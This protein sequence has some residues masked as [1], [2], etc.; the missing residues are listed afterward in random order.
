MLL[1]VGVVETGGTVRHQARL[2][3]LYRPRSIGARLPLNE[4]RYFMPRDALGA[5]ASEL[6]PG[7]GEVVM[8][9][10]GHFH[11]LTAARIHSAPGNL[12]LVVFDAHPDWS[13]APAGYVHCGSWVLEALAMPPVRAV[14]LVG[15]GELEARGLLQPPVVRGVEPAAREG[16]LRVYPARRST[17]RELHEAM[18]WPEALASL[19]DGAQALEDL[20]AFIGDGPVYLS[21]DK[22]VVRPEEL[23]GSWG[24]GEVGQLAVLRMVQ[25]LARSLPLLGADITGECVPSLCPEL[26]PVLRMHETFNLELLAALIP[27]APELR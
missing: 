17:V 27:D 2:M 14:A 11:H 10:E 12:G 20:V 16:R 1:G 26:D 8:L 21:I 15:V 13:P 25:A 4:Y 19:E 6:S 22:D 3:D 18:G 7:P 23:P 9:G 24:D 5:L